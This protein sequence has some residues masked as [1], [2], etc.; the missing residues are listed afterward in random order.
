MTCIA[1]AGPAHDGHSW[2]PRPA[3]EVS[4]SDVE[5]R[6]SAASFAGVDTAR[7]PLGP[8]RSGESCATAMVTGQGRSCLDKVTVDGDDQVIRF[9]I[10]Q[11]G[12]TIAGKAG[13]THPGRAAEAPIKPVPTR[14][15][16]MKGRLAFE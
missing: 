15:T 4:V 11:P 8:G 7:F 6:S 12:R 9:V 16:V 13:G 14:H 10:P 3:G 5:R 2:A 1:G